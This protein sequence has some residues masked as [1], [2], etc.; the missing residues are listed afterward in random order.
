MTKG[1]KVWSEIEKSS[2]DARIEEYERGF[3][4]AVAGKPLVRPKRKDLVQAYVNGYN[5]GKV[6]KKRSAQSE[7]KGSCHVDFSW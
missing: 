5:E 2:N 7:D 6:L 4:D 1:N 3:D